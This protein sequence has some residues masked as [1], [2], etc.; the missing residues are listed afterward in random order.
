M[1]YATAYHLVIEQVKPYVETD[2]N[3]KERLIDR[4]RQGKPPIPGQVTSILL[5]LKVIYEGLRGVS[6]LERELVLGLYR[7]AYESQ[8]WYDQGEKN[9]TEWPP[10][11]DTDLRRMA[12]AVSHIFSDRW[13]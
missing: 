3:P 1:D 9:G 13:E 10:L 4:L 6:N 2:L 8:Y 7:L 12:K 11:L 5:A